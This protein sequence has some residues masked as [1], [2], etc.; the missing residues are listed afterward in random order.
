MDA[1]IQSLERESRL[2]RSPLGP[3]S[4]GPS[5][6]VAIPEPACVVIRNL[7]ADTT[8]QSM[9]FMFAW[10]RQSLD[11]TVLP[12]DEGSGSTLRTAI[13]GFPSTG[14]ACEVKKMYDGM[15]NPNQDGEMV[16]EI[17]PPSHR[18]G[19]VS[20]GNNCFAHV[21]SHIN[22]GSS[23]GD[24]GQ[25]E[26]NFTAASSPS[27]TSPA[28]HVSRFAGSFQPLNSLTPPLSGELF[29]SGDVPS[30]FSPQSLINSY[31]SERP[32]ITGKTLI[33]NESVDEDDTGEL[34]LKQSLAS[35]VDAPFAPSSLQRRATA[36]QLPISRLASLSLNTGPSVSS[37]LPPNSHALRHQQQCHPKQQ[38]QQQQQH[39]VGTSSAHPI[40][41]TS[42][43]PIALRSASVIG[44][45]SP[46]SA[47]GM[48]TAPH[49]P[50]PH[51]PAAN[52]ADQN[53]P[54]NTLYVGNLPIDTSEEELKA[55]FSKQR[56][57]KRLCFRTKSNGPMCFVEFEDVSFATKAL[58][59]LYG[60]LLHNSIKGGIRLS[61]SKN[62]LGVRSG[63]VACQPFVRPMN[64]T[65]NV[66]GCG[67]GFGSISG[68]PP[69]LSPPPGLGPRNMSFGNVPAA[70]NVAS[71][72][73]S[74]H[75]QQ[76]YNK[77]VPFSHT[78]PTSSWNAYSNHS[79]IGSPTNGR[80]GLGPSQMFGH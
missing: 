18:H 53:P 78:P 42:V 32:R 45:P 71:N 16:V 56:G 61:F 22:S 38:Q 2:A 9:R 57:Y 27:V 39:F 7:P 50:R 55:I 11:V 44:S 12:S 68:P 20:S 35:I 64:G 70:A 21:A 5:Q 4:G 23:V 47:F 24:M 66:A 75:S 37:P 29:T 8:E 59:E 48:T 58:N 76:Q 54:C 30:L 6:G 40:D 10:T 1:Y 13:I 15:L 33:K 46:L 77:P 60:Q 51:Y 17:L 36:P 3:F 14:L 19:Q 31:L 49:H 63:Q 52:P 72:V 73:I 79:P 41:S 69:G 28:S 80:S 74:M 65:H 43:S 34:L 62:P 26:G 25:S 67:P